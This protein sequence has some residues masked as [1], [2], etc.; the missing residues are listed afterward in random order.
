VRRSLGGP[1]ENTAVT[2][3]DDVVR[4]DAQGSFSLEVIRRPQF[5]V[6]VTSPRPMTTSELVHPVMAFAGAVVASW[7]G[8]LSFHA[9]AVVLHGRAWLLLAPPA[10]GKSTLA[11]CLRA[12]GHAVLADDLAVLDGRTVLAGPRSADLREGAAGHLAVGVRQDASTGRQR[13][14]TDLGS[15]DHEVPL[16]GMVVLERDGEVSMR[17]TGAAERLEILA[18]FDALGRGPA[19]PTAFLDLLDVPIYE[20]RRPH[21][22]DALDATLS[23][24]EAVAAAPGGEPSVLDQH[25]RGVQRVLLLPGRGEAVDVDE[26]RDIG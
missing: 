16:G 21:D 4:L 26:F 22:W 8:R 18:A 24:I 6:R 15:A 10:G 5:S 3:S 20:L 9:A 7:T 23:S 12:R 1:P 17:K 13:W 14:R 19:T 2:W 25:H 11:A